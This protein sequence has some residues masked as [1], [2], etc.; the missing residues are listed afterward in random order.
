MKYNGS[1]EEL[2]YK[3]LIIQ[4][5]FKLIKKQTQDVDLLS[6]IGSYQD[7]LPDE[8]IY[9]LLFDYQHGGIWKSKCAEI[10]PDEDG[11]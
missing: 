6:I 1:E 5:C 9:Q 11:D 8:E 3:D 7:T 10:S 4:E 2:D